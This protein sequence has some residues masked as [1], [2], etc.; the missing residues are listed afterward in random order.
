MEN[1]VQGQGRDGTG[2]PV[3]RLSLL[4][5]FIGSSRRRAGEL[6]LA[7]LLNHPGILHK[8]LSLS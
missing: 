8:S 5:Y 6:S 7:V 2:V 3:G 1:I 4:L